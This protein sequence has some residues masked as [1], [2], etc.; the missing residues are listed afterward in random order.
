FDL[1]DVQLHLLA[2]ELLQLGT[3]A[4]GL[5]AATADHDA[6]TRGVDVHTHAV[7]GALDLDLR[8][9]RTLHAGGEELADRDVFLHVVRV[10]L[11]RVP[12]GL[13]IGGDTEAEAVGIDLLSH[14]LCPSLPAAAS[15]TGGGH[16]L[17]LDGDVA[18]ALADPKRAALGTRLETLQGRALVDVRGRDD[19]RRRVEAEVVLGVGRGAGHDLGDRLAR[20]LRS[21]L[22][23]REGV[24]DPLPRTRSTTRRA[25]I[26]VTRTCLAV[27]RAVTEAVSSA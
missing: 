7:T 22:Q 18:G 23:D 26:G 20:G 25:F 6:R 27:A 5:G 4:V 11:V 15:S 16:A 14:L 2:G 13:P 12:T 8:D 10:L 3:D 9:A 24:L 19:Q 17:D 21:E 1:E